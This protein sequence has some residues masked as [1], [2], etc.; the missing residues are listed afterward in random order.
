MGE[1]VHRL[2]E[3]QS[4]GGLE[5]LADG[6]DIQRHQSPALGGLLGQRDGGLYDF[7]HSD[8]AMGQFF[9]VGPKGVGVDNLTA[10]VQIGCVNVQ[11]PL[12]VFQGNQLRGCACGQPFGLEH[13]AHGAV[14]QDGLTGGE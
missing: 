4:A 2:F 3:F 13:G 5:Q 8:P 1:H 6:A 7:F 10:C 14:Q 9:S 12:G 11:Q